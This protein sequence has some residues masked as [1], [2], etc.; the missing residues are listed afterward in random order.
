MISTWLLWDI[1]AEREIELGHERQ[2]DRIF[3]Y[4][5]DG[6]VGWTIFCGPR[7]FHLLYLVIAIA[8]AIAGFH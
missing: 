5:A 3:S 4:L 7:A 8:I 2:S 1:F 6:P